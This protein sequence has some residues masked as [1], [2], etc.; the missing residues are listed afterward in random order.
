MG[1]K[2]PKFESTEP[3]A[4]SESDIAIATDAEV[5]KYATGWLLEDEATVAKMPGTGGLFGAPYGLP[6]EHS[7]RSA[8]VR[9]RW[10]KRT[11]MCV[12]MGL[13]TAGSI[14]LNVRKKGWFDFSGLHP[15]TLAR[16]YSRFSPDTPLFDAGC[17]PYS[18]AVGLREWGLLPEAELP[19]PDN[20][21]WD[22]LSLNK[23]L[24]WDQLQNATPWKVV[25][26]HR[27]DSSDPVTAAKQALANN[28]PVCIG[29][30]VTGGWFNYTKGQTIGIEGNTGGGGH[31]TTLVGYQGNNFEGVN[32]WNTTWGDGGFYRLDAAV[33][34][35]P[36]TMLY[37]F[38]WGT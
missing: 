16:Q 13:S 28:N 33:L 14:W 38:S 30:Y 6:Y 5:A 26:V 24:A 4:E 27:I 21:A 11:S 35:D 29:T 9:I 20:D 15:Y 1:P 34:R 12:G 17:Y 31:L 23:D 8:V 37:V 25:G 7:M 10:Q 18:A 36:R 32:S 19:S 22:P 3:A 2:R